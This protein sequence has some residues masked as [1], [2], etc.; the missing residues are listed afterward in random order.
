MEVVAIAGYTDAEKLSIARQHLL[1]RA[2]AAHGLRPSEVA[3]G[4]DAVQRVVRGYTREA[5]VRNLGRELGGVLRKVACHVSGGVTVPVCVGQDDVRAYLGAASFEDSAAERIDRPGIAM[6]LAWMPT[7]G[8]ILFVEATIMPAEEDDLVLTG[9]MG[10]VM[11]ES[12]RAALSYL[13]SNMARYR[14][15]L[16]AFARKTVHVHVPAGAIP[17]DGPSAGVTIL[18]ALASAASGRSVRFD[19]AMTG[20]ITLRG[21]VLP[22]GGVKEKVLA[23]HRAGL[24]RI[25]LPRRCESQFDDVPENV[26]GDIE[27]TFVDSAE[28]ALSAALIAAPEQA[29]PAAR[30]VDRSPLSVRFPA[31]RRAG[32]PDGGFSF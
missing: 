4:D 23:A 2:I 25:I 29:E 28:E 12:A 15:D 24:R 26:R 30:A 21:R 3:I 20:E 13:R 27:A 10:S 5:G 8:E 7:G 32:R 14:I 16:R 11:R 17:K 6:G 1:P 18:V 9:M 31:P 19:M 22:V